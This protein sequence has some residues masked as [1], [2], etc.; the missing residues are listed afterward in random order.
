MRAEQHW[1]T[2]RSHS[3]LRPRQCFQSSRVRAA[4]R[5]S[6][7]TTGARH[8]GSSRSGRNT[9]SSAGFSWLSAR[10]PPRRACGL[11]V[12]QEREPLPRDWTNSPA[13]MSS[14]CT[15]DGCAARTGRCRGG[16]STTWP[17]RRQ[18]SGSSTP[19][20]TRERLRSDDL[21]PVQPASRESLHQR[22]GPDALGPRPAQAGCGRPNSA[23]GRTCRRTRSRRP[24]LCRDGAALVR[25]QQHRRRAAGRASRADQAA[26]ING[27]SRARR[28]GRRRSISPSTVP[29]GGG[30]TGIEHSSTSSS[31]AAGNGAYGRAPSNPGGPLCGR[32]GR[33]ACRPDP[34]RRTP[35]AVAIAREAARPRQMA[36]ALTDQPTA[37]AGVCRRSACATVGAS[38]RPSGDALSIS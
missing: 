4:R 15:T 1:L 34:A 35:R 33:C 17:S 23:R 38:P 12:L 16:T 3:S 10:S 27:R 24:V 29:A 32:S 26:S 6:A 8:A 14:R 7:S 30:L 13:S 20:R 5:P 31:T 28:P 11:K 37:A 21:G 2:R 19:R 25:E 9:R 22:P 18:A 36:T